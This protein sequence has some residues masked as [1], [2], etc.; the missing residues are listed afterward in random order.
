VAAPAP[1]LPAAP[2]GDGTRVPLDEALKKLEGRG[3]FM[4]KLVAK[5]RAK[6]M[7]TAP[8]TNLAGSESRMTGNTGVAGGLMR[9]FLGGVGG[10]Y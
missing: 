1:G 2:A 8:A 5:L 10:S 9:G 7:T 6:A 4:S 3:P